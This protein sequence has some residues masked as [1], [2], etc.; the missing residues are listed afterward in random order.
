MKVYQK[1]QAI[2]EEAL[3]GDG[4]ILLDKDSGFTF[5]LNYFGYYIWKNIEDYT[6][7]GMTD[8]I[9][10]NTIR[11]EEYTREDIGKYISDYIEVLKKSGLVV[12]RSLTGK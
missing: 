8:Y 5:I 4:A 2:L 7:E 12:G 3:E 1:N 9:Y 10:E 6:P 11:T